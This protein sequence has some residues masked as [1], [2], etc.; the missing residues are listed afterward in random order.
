MTTPTAR[1]PRFPVGT[2]VRIADLDDLARF[3]ADRRQHHSLE[4][5]QLEHAGEVT[6]VR[7]ISYYHTGDP[8]YTLENVPG[9]WHEACLRQR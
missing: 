2:G 1:E 6:T 3:M 5:V 9:V 8:L 4:S 7:E